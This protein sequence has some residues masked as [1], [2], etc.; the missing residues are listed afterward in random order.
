MCAS[1]AAAVTQ[2]IIYFFF[3]QAEDGIR[4]KLVTGVQTCALPISRGG[5]SFTL[6]AASLPSPSRSFPF[7]PAGR[8]PAS[9][10][11]VTLA[12]LEEGLA[13]DAEDPRGLAAIVAGQ[14]RDLADVRL[15]ELGQ[16]VTPVH[17][18]RDRGDW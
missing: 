9:G 2:S 6:R 14:S 4:D 16:G 18:L 11:P 8:A 7:G 15:L 3:F 1:A 13:V 12:F 5:A 10:N 17:C